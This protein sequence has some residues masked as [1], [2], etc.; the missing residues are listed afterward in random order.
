MSS[1]AP[2][3]VALLL[4]GTELLTGKIRDENGPL[5]VSTFAASG[6]KLSEIRVVHDDAPIIADAVRQMRRE[7]DY[8]ITS[9]GIGPTHDDVTLRAV[10]DAL[11]VDLVRDPVLMEHV[12]RVFGDDP[13]SVEVWARMAEVPEGTTFVPM[14]GRYWPVYRARNIFILPGVPQ[15]FAKQ[16]ERIAPEFFGIPIHAA[17]LYVTIGEGPIATPLTDATRRFP[18]VDFGSY[19]IW[20]NDKFRTRLTVESASQ[21]SVKRAASW[22]VEALGEEVVVEVT[23]D[24]RGLRG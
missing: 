8:V 2:N 9:G 10:A 22:L 19:P 1:E 13:K 24:E 5:C 3:S 12:V 23:Y 11:D 4:I 18:G 7:A 14:T 17:V 6:V 16:L 15:L 20:G 21:E